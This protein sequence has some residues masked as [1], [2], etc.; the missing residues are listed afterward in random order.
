M[1][2]IKLILLYLFQGL[3][4]GLHLIKKCM[5][6]CLNSKKKHEDLEIKVLEAG[7]NQSEWIEMLE[8]LLNSKKI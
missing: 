4:Q 5:I 1:F 2:L 8:K 6:L 7:F 3:F